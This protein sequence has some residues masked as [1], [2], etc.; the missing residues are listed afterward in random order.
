MPLKPSGRLLRTLLAALLLAAVAGAPALSSAAAGPQRVVILP[1]TANAKEDIGFLVQGVRDMLA[2][3][4]AWQ[5][6]VSVVEPDLVRPVMQEIPPP[7]DED[8]AL[9]MA[10]RLSADVVV[11]GS[12]THLGKAV[13][14]DATVV[15]ADQPGQPLT[16]FVQASELDQVIPRVNDFAQ[17]VNAEV[18]QRP[19]AVA[20]LEEAKKKTQDR[21]L[22]KDTEQGGAGP[23]AA[24]DEDEG[25]LPPNISPLNPLFLKSLSGVEGDRYWRSP[26]IDGQI[27]SLAVADVDLDDKNEV[28]ALMPDSLRIYRLA[29]RHFALVRKLDNGP[30]GEYLFVDAADIN[31]NG[32]PEIFVTNMN[33][34]SLES[35]VLEYQAD[36][37]LSYVAKDLPYYF[38]VQKDP[39]DTGKHILLAQQKDVMEAFAGPIYK[40]GFDGTTYVPRE[41]LPKPDRYLNVCNMLLADLNGA[42]RAATLMIGPSWGLHVFQGG[43][44]IYTSE[45]A[46]QATA[47][48]V[49]L[50][51]GASPGTIGVENMWYFLPARMVLSDLDQNGRAEVLVLR[52]RDRLLD[53][54]GKM[55][56]Y[57]Q[58]TLYSLYWNG[59]SLVENWRTPRISGYVTDYALGDAGNVGRPALVIAVN[60]KTMGGF[61]SKDQA[62]FVAFTL[63]PKAA[64]TPAPM[65]EGL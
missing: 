59:L 25:D 56:A 50:P 45:D 52:N 28:L 27:A 51:P 53:L 10:R 44:E 46:Y 48:F 20:A 1:F 39:L 24:G 9:R 57:Y 14:V 21:Y 4:L 63:K 5:D 13:S 3:R 12:I 41:E 7:Y 38:R 60:N 26:R 64:E 58:G 23:R 65:K 42:G 49:E 54:L 37:S 62:H 31:G 30:K 55:K 8:K 18:F 33:Y 16:T 19:E 43:Q 29:E 22:P 40:M 61:A 15:R 36:G 34:M 32:R 11:Y 17:R 35:F 2:T 47:K 6:K